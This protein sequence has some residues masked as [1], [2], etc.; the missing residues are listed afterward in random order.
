M[1]PTSFL[2]FIF[3]SQ[4]LLLNGDFVVYT[5]VHSTIDVITGFPFFLFMLKILM[6]TDIWVSSTVGTGPS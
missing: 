5:R 1:V 4:V 3:W 2:P 6:G